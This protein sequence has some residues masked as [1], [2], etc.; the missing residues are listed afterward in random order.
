MSVTNK[1]NRT[2]Q[3]VNYSE[4]KNFSWW[5]VFL[6][7]L[8]VEITFPYSLGKQ[9]NIANNIL[10]NIFLL[11]ETP[12]RVSIK[13]YFNSMDI[14][15][16]NFHIRWCIIRLASDYLQKTWILY[17]KYEFMSDKY[18]FHVTVVYIKMPLFS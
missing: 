10:C 15:W 9:S 4:Q 8:S 18:T 7:L 12:M 6:C 11:N 16:R 2:L 3:L 5:N 13:I 1:G 17:E 14:Y